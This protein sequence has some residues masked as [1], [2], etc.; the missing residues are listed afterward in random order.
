VGRR[1]F[2]ELHHGPQAEA[3]C[4]PQ[5]CQSSLQQVAAI[6][7]QQDQVGDQAERDEV[8][9]CRGMDIRGRVVRDERLGQL[10]GH[11]D[12]G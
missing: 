11:A 5:P 1:Q 8:Q 2:G 9:Q 10:I 4:I 3:L 7:G 12:A 6:A